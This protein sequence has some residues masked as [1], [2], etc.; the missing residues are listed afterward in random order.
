MKTINDYDIA[1]VK[2][3][4]TIN[5][6]VVDNWRQKLGADSGLEMVFKYD[7]GEYFE[8]KQL[9]RSLAHKHVRINLDKMLYTGCYSFDDAW[10]L[11]KKFK[12]NGGTVADLVD[13]DDEFDGDHAEK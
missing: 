5:W 6:G 8:T 10:E 9:N 7:T 11:I 12:Q 1:Q 13:E 3:A 4:R 2:I